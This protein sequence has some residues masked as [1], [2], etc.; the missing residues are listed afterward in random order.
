MS[1][2]CQLIKLAMTMQ[3][4]A[5]NGSATTLPKS[6]LMP[7]PSESMSFVKRAISSLV[8]CLSIWPMSR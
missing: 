1:V 5:F 7:R 2:S 8:P 4:S 6:I 3:L